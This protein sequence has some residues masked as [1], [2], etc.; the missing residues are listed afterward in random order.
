MCRQERHCP[1]PGRTGGAPVAPQA[2][3]PPR[4]LTRRPRPLL[5]P[6]RPPGC[7][8]PRPRTSPSPRARGHHCHCP[9]G[10]TPW[11]TCTRHH[12]GPGHMAAQGHP[13]DRGYTRPAHTCRSAHMGTAAHATT[14]GQDTRPHRDTR[15]T[16]GTHGRHTHAKVHTRAAHI[17]VQSGP[18]Q[19]ADMHNRQGREVTVP[20]ELEQSEI[21]RAEGKR[22]YMFLSEWGHMLSQRVS[23]ELG[24]KRNGTCPQA[25]QFS[26]VLSFPALSPYCSL[27]VFPLSPASLRL[28][29]S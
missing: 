4:P 13:R 16:V 10:D 23:G 26:V 19:S 3:C 11:A 12:T 17:T 6:P 2:T 24:E 7:R 18:A 27:P 20:G 28:K 22:C 1:H 5:P 21:K 14:Q 25:L 9:T 15:G 29:S 8:T